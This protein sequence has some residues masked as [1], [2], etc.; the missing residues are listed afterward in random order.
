L[1]PTSSDRTSRSVVPTHTA[2]PHTM[3]ER[4]TCTRYLARFGV[5]DPSG[6]KSLAP[7]RRN[8]STAQAWQRC[9]MSSIAQ[10]GLSQTETRGATPYCRGISSCGATRW[11]RPISSLC[12]SFFGKRISRPGEIKCVVNRDGRVAAS[13]LWDEGTRPHAGS[14]IAAPGGMEA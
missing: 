13:L 10:I 12:S 5:S 14:S 2:H 6:R 9:G 8:R 1:W 3:Q 7:G 4:R 11:P